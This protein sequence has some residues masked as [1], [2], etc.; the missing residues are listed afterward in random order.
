M[1]L[2]FKRAQTDDATGK[3]KVKFKLWAQTELDE[4]EQH[5][6]KRYLRWRQAHRRVPT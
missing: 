5:I 3:V 4:D 1:N 2:L 6:V